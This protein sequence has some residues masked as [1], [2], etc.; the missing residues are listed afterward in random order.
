VKPVSIPLLTLEARLKRRLRA[1]LTQIGFRRDDDGLLTPPS[2][3]EGIR[4]MH[5]VQRQSVLRDSQDFIKTSWETL[6][7]YL[8]SGFDVEPKRIAPRLEPIRG[9]TWQSDLFRLVSLT[10]SVPV[11]EGFGRRMRFLVWDDHCGKLLGVMGLTDPVFNL[12]A[13]D[14]YI[15]WSFAIR[16][17][18]L[19]HLMDAFVLGAVPPYSYLLGG[20]M[21]AC[22]VRSREVAEEFDRRYRSTKG[23]ISGRRKQARLAAVTTSSAL[24]RS[25]IYNRLRLNGNE[26]F[27]RVGYTG[28]WGHFHISGDLFEMIREYLTMKGHRYA[29]DNRFGDGP[30]WRLRAVRQAL[31]LLGIRDDLLRHGIAREVFI[32]ELA[33]NARQFL[34]GIESD[35]DY[36]SLPTALAVGELARDRWSVPRAER[37][38]EYRIWHKETLLATL[39]G[40]SASSRAKAV[41]GK[42]GVD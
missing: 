37:R 6:S 1:H 12:R 42:H 8:A 26:V 41:G 33:V 4:A 36:S 23:V 9:G 10:W 16:R 38:P 20:K 27:R 24:G 5:G 34:R 32:T 22:L 31:D 30:N 3:K 18:R 40:K 25:S 15:G 39:L 17:K 21:V 14:D 35:P 28:G 13:R 2:T 19:V 29:A 7:R 11:S